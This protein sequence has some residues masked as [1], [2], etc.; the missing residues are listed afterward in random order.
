MWLA[1]ALLVL[2]LVVGVI[3]FLFGY[4]A[5]QEDAQG[6]PHLV[7]DDPEPSPLPYW[8][9]P[10]SEYVQKQKEWSDR[11]FGPPKFEDSERLCRHIEKEL[12]EIRLRPYDCE[13]WAD[14]II[15]A[16]EGAWRNGHSPL[17]IAWTLQHKQEKNFARQWNIPADPMTPIE[18]YR[19]EERETNP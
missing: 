2:V 9:T 7:G 15:L 6:L 10:I 11:T 18:H 19:M 14:V 1:L 16:L 13:E 8:N 12:K 5:A 4:R 17:S 3:G